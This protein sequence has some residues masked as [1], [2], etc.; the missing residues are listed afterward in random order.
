MYVH[1]YLKLTC[2]AIEYIAALMTLTRVLALSALT[3]DTL[4]F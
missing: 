2:V 4:L 3:V 1:S